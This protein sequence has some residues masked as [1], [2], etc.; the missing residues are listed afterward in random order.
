MVGVIETGHCVSWIK[1]R[2]FG[3]IRSDETGW[4]VF[5]HFRAFMDRRFQELSPGTRVSFRRVAGR[6]PGQEQA[7]DVSILD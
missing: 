5:V 7:A 6:E 2:G 1:D 3:F 4:D